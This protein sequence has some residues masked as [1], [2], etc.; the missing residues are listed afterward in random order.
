MHEFVYILHLLNWPFS[1]FLASEND[2]IYTVSLRYLSQFWRVMVA[3]KRSKGII[4]SS[5]EISSQGKIPFSFPSKIAKN[6]IRNLIC[7]N[8]SKRCRWSGTV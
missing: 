8:E 4:S 1:A 2:V 7:Y 3:L 5:E 6:S